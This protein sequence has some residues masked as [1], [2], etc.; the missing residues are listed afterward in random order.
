MWAEWP[1][2]SPAGDARKV[3][4]S[5]QEKNIGMKK[6]LFFAFLLALTA[7]DTKSYKNEKSAIVN[8]D[9]LNSRLFDS[10][11]V[12]VKYNL[13]NNF[14]SQYHLLSLQSYK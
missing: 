1:V 4:R 13:Q 3:S 12:F 9:I 5:H 8:V 6:E 11:Q 7:C 10:F 2:L 14:K